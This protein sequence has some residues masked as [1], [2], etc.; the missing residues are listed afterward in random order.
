[1]G[2]YVDVFCTQAL[3]LS[4]LVTADEIP[5]PQCLEIHCRLNGKTMQ[6]GQ[7]GD[8]IFS[9]AELIAHLSRDTTLLP[10]TLILTG[11]PAGVGFARKPPLFL[12]DGDEVTVEITNVG[13]L[14]NPVES[15]G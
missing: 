2:R 9:V 7:T 5:D 10:G 8:M 4:Y 13:R 11:T 1:M 6:A 14:S 15:A 12:A 3:I